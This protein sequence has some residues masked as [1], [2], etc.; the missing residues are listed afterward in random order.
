[1]LSSLA[2]LMELKMLTK[3]LVIKNKLGLHT[4]AA[5]KLVSTAAK[6][7]S[8]IQLHH[9]DK[10]ADCKSIM[11]VILLGA[12]YG[13]SMN[14]ITDGDDEQKAQEVIYNLFETLFGE[15]E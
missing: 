5:A 15:S 1:M 9:N 14:L 2:S 7:E 13:A 12:A 6:F 4:R 3:S 11:S 8:K 10:I